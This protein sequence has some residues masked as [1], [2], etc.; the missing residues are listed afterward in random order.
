MGLGDASNNWNGMYDV[1]TK[2]TG[3]SNWDF[4]SLSEDSHF[5]DKLKATLGTIGAEYEREVTSLTNKIDS[6]NSGMTSYINTWLTEEW[7]FRKMHSGIQNI[8]KDI[9]LSNDWIDSLPEK[10]NPDDWEAVSEWLQ[11]N[12]LSA[13]NNIESEEI[14]ASL[15]DMMLMHYFTAFHIK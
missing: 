12:L 3:V 11:N 6:A 10:V 1:N 9:L 2:L 7:G 8:V 4:S 13:I 5:I 15:T 14:L